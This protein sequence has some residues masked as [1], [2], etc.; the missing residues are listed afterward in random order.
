MPTDDKQLYVVRKDLSGGSNSRQ[1]PTIIGENQSAVLENIDIGVMGE[2]RKRSGL[3]SIADLTV[4]AD[5]LFGFDPDG[6]TFK[7]VASYEGMLKSWTP[8]SPTFASIASVGGLSSGVPMSFVKAGELGEGDVLI[9]SNGT[10]YALRMNQTPTF[11]DIGN[12]STSSMPKT[13]VMA[14]YRNI[15]WALVDGNL[16]FSDAYPADYSVAFAST[17]AFRLPVGT[18][19]ALIGL[20]DV[21]IVIMGSDQIWGLNPSAPPVSTDKPEK[22]LEIGCAASNTAKMV[23]DDVLFLAKDGVRGLFRTQQDKLQ[24]GLAFPLSFPLKTEFEDI[25][26]S[27]ITKACSVVFDNKYFI[28]LPTG[29]STYNNQVWVFYPA[30]KAWVVIKGWNVGGWATL[31]INGEER[32][33]AIDSNSGMVY[34]CWS[35]TDDNG[36][37]VALNF[38]SRQEDLGQPLVEKIGGELEIES[39][40]AGSVS[41]L[42]IYVSIDGSDFQLLRTLDISSAN[43]PEL[44]VTLP[45]TLADSYMVRNKIHLDSLGNWRTLQ[46]KIL[47]SQLNALPIIIYGYNI[48]TFAEEYIN[49]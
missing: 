1:H 28:S 13:S 48:I 16:Y 31:R 3:A 33:Y 9:L 14:Y 45:F 26:W 27:Q 29:I 43:A 44:P 6:G 32:L 19:R 38:T 30:L 49:E 10:D 46:I 24:A 35:G 2:A 40:V 25:D 39:E 20:R 21:G 47:N 17:N 42:L 12:A 36:T 37:A 18:E 22:L 5:G 41:A 8:D 7:L 34:R 23:G 4:V 15:L 11:Q